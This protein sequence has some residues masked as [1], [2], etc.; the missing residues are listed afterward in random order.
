M[1]VFLQTFDDSPKCF[2]KA[3]L[4]RFLKRKKKAAEKINK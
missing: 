3:S 2:T 4:K 1:P